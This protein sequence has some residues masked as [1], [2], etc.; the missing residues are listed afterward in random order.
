MVSKSIE[1]FFE[2]RRNKMSFQEYS[3]E[4]DIRL[5]EAVTRAGLELN[6]VGKFYLFFKGSGLPPKFVEDTKLQIQGDLRRF[7][8]TRT[9]ALRLIS[10]RNDSGLDNFYQGD[11]YQ[12][13]DYHPETTT[14]QRLTST[15]TATTATSGMIPPGKKMDRSGTRAKLT[16]R[17]TRTTIGTPRTTTTRM[18]Q[19]RPHRLSF[20]ETTTADSGAQEIYPMHKGGKG[21]GAAS[22]DPDG[23]WPPRVLLDLESPEVK[24]AR[25]QAKTKGGF[26]FS[27]SGH[28]STGYGKSYSKGK[29]YSR[30]K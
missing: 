4:W 21:S 1:E 27:S 20:D 9:L 13:D 11:E 29:S 16:L 26:P 18:L 8:E 25:V 12:D 22:V 30:G 10:R 6:D 23:I 2:F 28:G 19:K 17:T 14:T 5:E 7:Q 24:A 15:L 3:I